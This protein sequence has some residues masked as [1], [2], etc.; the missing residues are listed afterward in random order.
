M[1]VTPRIGQDR[2]QLVN[3]PQLLALY[4]T[5]L[6]KETSAI[7]TATCTRIRP[8]VTLTVNPTPREVCEA[9]GTTITQHVQQSRYKSGI[10]PC[11]SAISPMATIMCASRE[12]PHL[13]I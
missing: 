7:E 1:Y 10:V 5:L 12:M 2:L 13:R 8:P 11:K 4:A 3:E 6:E 9:C